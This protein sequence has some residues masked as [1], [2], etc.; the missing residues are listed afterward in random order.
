MWDPEEGISFR[1]PFLIHLFLLTLLDPIF[2][3]FY[4]HTQHDDVL[5]LYRAL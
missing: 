4:I 1:I 2:F 3:T 5:S